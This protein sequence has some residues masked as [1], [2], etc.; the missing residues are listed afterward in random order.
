MNQPEAI[1]YGKWFFKLQ[2]E[3]IKKG[4]TCLKYNSNSNNGV[5]K[6]NVAVFGDTEKGMYLFTESSKDTT[7]SHLKSTDIERKDKDDIDQNS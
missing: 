5:K 2:V 7:N 4:I 1:A 3:E 6:D